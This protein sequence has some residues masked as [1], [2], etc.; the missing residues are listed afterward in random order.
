MGTMEDF[1]D[2]VKFVT[3]QHYLFI[4]VQMI[5][6]RCTK[7]S[8]V[9]NVLLERKVNQ[10]VMVV[11]IVVLVNIKMKKDYRFAS[12][13]PLDTNRAKQVKHIARHVT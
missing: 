12:I 11:L 6:I 1:R 3:K 5:L 4:L 13:V 7:V 9:E 2:V 8:F 10:M